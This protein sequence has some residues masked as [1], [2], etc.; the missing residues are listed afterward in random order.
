M[1]TVDADEEYYETVLE[2]LDDDQLETVA[3]A[4][5]TLGSVAARLEEREEETGVTDVAENYGRIAEHEERIERL[6]L[7]LRE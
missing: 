4:A 1:T 6:A 7:E 2:H 5:A 3:E